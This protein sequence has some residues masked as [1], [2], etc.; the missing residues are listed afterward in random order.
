MHELLAL[1]GR[2][3]VGKTNIL[4]AIEWAAGIESL[5]SGIG[6][7]IGSPIRGDIVLRMTLGNQIFR[8]AVAVD[9]D[10]EKE[11]EIQAN[12]FPAFFLKEEL[13][14]ESDDGGAE[15]MIFSLNRG[16]LKVG[17]GSIAAK[18]GSLSP[19]GSA[20]LALYPDHKVAPLL[21]EV[22]AFLSAIRYYP[23]EEIEDDGRANLFVSNNE[24]QTWVSTRSKTQGANK[25][26][27]LKILDLKLNRPETFNELLALLGPDGLALISNILVRTFEIPAAL[28]EESKKDQTRKYHFI[29]FAPTGTK[30]ESVYPFSS[31]S[32]GTRR[33]IR[34]VTSVVYDDASVS[35]IEQPEDGIHHGLLHKLIP[36]LRSYANPKQFLVTSHSTAVFNRIEPSEIRLVDLADGQTTIRSL[37]ATELSAAESF[38]ENDGP[39]S[40]FVESVQEQ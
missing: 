28:E 36:L 14:I 21:R 23:L 25:L 24:F 8:Y 10:M 19:G 33:I 27:L 3:G 11:S 20:I 17:D 39:L 29:E 30:E 7:D 4:K 32:F 12:A 40:E 6:P 34:L 31:L 2:N 35:L 9:F 22:I 1:I 15:I 13:T 5:P 16:D 38:M 18:I 37:T 26:I